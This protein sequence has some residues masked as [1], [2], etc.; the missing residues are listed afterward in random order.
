MINNYLDKN[1]VKRTNPSDFSLFIFSGF[2]KF[3]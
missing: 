1:D 3:N 2:E